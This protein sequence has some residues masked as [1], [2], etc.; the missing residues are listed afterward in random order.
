MRG[1]R[2]HRVSIAV[3]ISVSDEQRLLAGLH[4]A[5]GILFVTI[6][7]AVRDDTG[8]LLSEA[9]VTWAS[10]VV[11][12]SPLVVRLLLAIRTLPSVSHSGCAYVDILSTRATAEL[13]LK[14][15]GIWTLVACTGGLIVLGTAAAGLIAGLLVGVSTLSTA[16][17]FVIRRIEMRRRGRL[18]RH[19]GNRPWSFRNGGIFATRCLRWVG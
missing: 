5:L 3:L 15:L 12:L 18:C 9:A 2:R 14:R 8:D 4:F 17:A 19:I 10:I 1:V 13:I 7:L 16:G 11:A 6:Q